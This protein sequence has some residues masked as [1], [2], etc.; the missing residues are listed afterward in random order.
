MAIL[1][2][3]QRR[4]MSTN[5]V[6]KG[7]TGITDVS[8]GNTS[9]LIAAI[10]HGLFDV[11]FTILQI[12]QAAS[13]IRK[14]SIPLILLGCID[15]Q[16]SDAIFSSQR[17]V[18]IVF[19]DVLTS[20]LLHSLRPAMTSNHGG[21][22]RFISLLLQLG[23]SPHA[24][25][26]APTLSKPIQFTRQVG[27]NYDMPLVTSYG[28]EKTSALQRIVTAYYDKNK[29]L[30]WIPGPTQANENKPGA[31]FDDIISGH[32]SDKGHKSNDI[33]MNPASNKVALVT[34]Q[35]YQLIDGI[36]IANDDPSLLH[37]LITNCE[38]RD[39]RYHLA[40]VAYVHGMS[41]IMLN[42]VAPISGAT[43]LLTAMSNPITRIHLLPRL[44]E[45]GASRQVVD[46]CGHGLLEYIMKTAFVSSNPNR[47]ISLPY[48]PNTYPGYHSN[49][50][51]PSN[52]S[53]KDDNKSE[54]KVVATT[55]SE[56]NDV[57]GLDLALQYISEG[58]PIRDPTYILSTIIK[59]IKDPYSMPIP[60]MQ[61]H[62]GNFQ[63]LSQQSLQLFQ[64]A[65]HA[66]ADISNSHDD[67]LRGKTTSKYRSMLTTLIDNISTEMGG[68]TP[69]GTPSM[70][71]QQ[72]II[73]LVE[74]GA[75]PQHFFHYAPPDPLTQ[76]QLHPLRYSPYHS[77]PMMASN[78]P[79]RKVTNS[80]SLHYLD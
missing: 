52:S 17:A 48:T 22:V 58:V 67:L 56:N 42:S 4:E 71:L 61:P 45:R 14:Q 70:I 35:L 44:L 60:S 13:I 37:Q 51:T 21:A 57:N 34:H 68:Y 25:A 30:T 31:D 20:V 47:I 7:I 18:N 73:T 80:L 63:R 11:A 69:S 72:M 16:W 19:D 12:I 46:R 59:G 27:E 9:P 28:T 40:S 15:D 26:A 66:G 50:T 32:H 23:A 36:M 24:V 64:M 75:E 38:C 41:D 54:T 77:M 43:P 3:L 5:G 55:I 29:S 8:E 62:M 53:K 1:N 49:I 74:N 2:M 10:T 39:D 6:I 78:S 79:W 65:I 76:P 33:M